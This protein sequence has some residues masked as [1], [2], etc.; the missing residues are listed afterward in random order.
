MYESDD[1]TCNELWEEW[2]LWCYCSFDE[3]CEA[4][5]DE[6]PW[7]EEFTLTRRARAN[8]KKKTGA[9]PTIQKKL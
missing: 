8:L 9:K 3:I 5:E 2:D 6:M 7:A 1:Q 4:V